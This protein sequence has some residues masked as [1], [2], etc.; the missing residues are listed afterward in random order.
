MADDGT[1]PPPEEIVLDA[2]D[3]DTKIATITLNR[4]ID[5]MRR[6]SRRGTA[7]RSSSI[8]PISTMRSRS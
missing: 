5:I 6:P 2:K 8:A 3:P 1:P 4:P 7:L